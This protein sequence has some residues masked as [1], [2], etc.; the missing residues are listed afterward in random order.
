MVHSKLR[1]GKKEKNKETTSTTYPLL[2]MRHKQAYKYLVN[3]H[4]PAVKHKNNTYNTILYYFF[5]LNM[6]LNLY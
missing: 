3:Q 1:K 2:N 6:P 4:K 5:Q